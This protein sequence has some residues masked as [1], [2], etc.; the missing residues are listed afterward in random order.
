M[1]IFSGNSEN[2]PFH[3]AHKR[4]AE[5]IMSA[6]GDSVDE[7]FVRQMI[8]HHRG[9]IDMSG[10]LLREGSDPE[11]K[12]MVQKSVSDQRKEIGELEQWLQTHGLSRETASSP[13][14]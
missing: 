14:E 12:Q 5:N 4:M 3:D 13:N 2:N 1:G 9:A 10:I 7:T 6:E 11:L 8:E